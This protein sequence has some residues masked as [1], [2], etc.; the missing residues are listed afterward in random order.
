M[1]PTCKG[2][3]EEALPEVA[4]L[5]NHHVMKIPTAVMASAISIQF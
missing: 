4:Y 2:F 3:N 1:N 5:S